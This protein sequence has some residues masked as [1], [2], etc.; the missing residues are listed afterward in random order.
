MLRI[1]TASASLGAAPD[2]LG[3][4][5]VRSLR[6]NGIPTERYEAC[7]DWWTRH[8]FQGSFP[9]HARLYK[10]GPATWGCYRILRKIQSGDVVW[11]LGSP[12]PND[13]SCKFEKAILKKPAFY[14]LHLLDDWF[15]HAHL[16]K[17]VEARIPLAH[18]VAVTTDALRNRLLQFFPKSTV[19]TIEEPVDVERLTPSFPSVQGKRSLVV[20]CGNPYN[21]KDLA[22]ME[23][24]LKDVYE[25]IPF[26]FR[27][28][29]GHKRPRLTLS[30][31]WEWVAYDY[32][33]ESNLI[34]GAVAGLAPLSDST[35]ARCKGAYKI[36]TY[37]A[38]GVPPV[39]SNVGYHKSLIKNGETGFLVNTR[40]QWKEALITLLRDS[41]L[42]ARVKRAARQEAVAKYSHEAV[43]PAWAAALRTHFP[44][45]AST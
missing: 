33:R 24:I 41:A 5:T 20:W 21:L 18:L 27:I 23:S 40:D 45:I 11:V 39:A 28:I 17:L 29:S 36:K 6:D 26:D 14:L 19:I 30:I 10:Y 8:L 2:V 32:K 7:S 38:S 43:I 4:K 15:S 3:P 9:F 1:V 13:L 12:L 37:L 16:R 22:N 31:P 35:Y 44:Q 34:S 25:Q 42:A